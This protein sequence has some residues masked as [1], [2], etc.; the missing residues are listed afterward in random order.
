MPLFSIIVPV[1]NAEETIGRCLCSIQ[2]QKETDFE[3]LVIEN[4]SADTSREICQGF[5]GEDSR[6]RLYCCETNCG[7]SGARN[8]GL[9]HVTGRYIA[10]VDSD[11]FVE[12]DYLESLCLALQTADVAF[13]GYKKILPDG[14]VVG[15]C[16][17]TVSE[18]EDYR[19]VL[20]Q[21]HNQDLFG[22]TWVKA[23]RREAIGERRFSEE[24][25][26]LEDEVFTCNILSSPM[27]V[28]VI[29]KAIYNY[30]S[31]NQGSLMGRTHQDY[32]RKVDQAYRA[33][34]NLL[35]GY[36]NEETELQMMANAHVNRCIYYGFERD[37]N[38]EVFFGSLAESTFFQD[39][40]DYTELYDFVKNKN[41][42]KLSR[43]RSLYRLKIR[44]AKLLRWRST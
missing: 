16:L 19:E 13:F 10:F 43:M 35:D 3:V 30:V 24:L 20:L 36:E 37:V 41:M 38:I 8:M 40:S 32:C 39:A 44:T 21:L 25:N 26:L 28:A 1:Y 6:I 17:P 18:T 11:D 22:Y 27:R 29:P 34:K 14:S 4:G 2:A 15:E 33:W 23:F 7:P 12:P 9:K 42:K 31:G 5:A